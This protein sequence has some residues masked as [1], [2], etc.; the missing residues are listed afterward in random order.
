MTAEHRTFINVSDNCRR[1]TTR[2]NLSDRILDIAKKLCETVVF[3]P[4]ELRGKTLKQDSL[5]AVCVYIACRDAQQD[6]KK[7]EVLAVSEVNEKAFNKQYKRVM[8]V[9]HE[10]RDRTAKATPGV[11]RID[12][13]NYVQRYVELLGLPEHFVDVVKCIITSAKEAQGHVITTTQSAPLAA[14]AI[15]FYAKL[16]QVPIDVARVSTVSTTSAD[17]ITRTARELHTVRERVVP[18]AAVDPVSLRNML[19]P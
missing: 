15:Y 2:L 16:Q 17:T 7:D 4:V 6:R 3:A 1:I 13:L 5:A 10:T 18:E 19:R 8:T 11:L 12:A 14:A 9:R